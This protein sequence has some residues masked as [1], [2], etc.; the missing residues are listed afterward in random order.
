MCLWKLLADCVH[1]VAKL[2]EKFSFLKV[3]QSFISTGSSDQTVMLE[4]TELFD[5]AV[6]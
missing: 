6:K 2:P 4:Q 3:S 5:L 1:F